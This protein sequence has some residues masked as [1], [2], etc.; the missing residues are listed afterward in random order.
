MITTVRETMIEAI[1]RSYW[2][3]R[4]GYGPVAGIS[5]EA[6][7]LEVRRLASDI[8]CDSSEIAQGIDR[9]ERRFTHATH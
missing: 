7:E 1:A 8:N 5:A 2:S 4:V 3:A 9:G 6:A